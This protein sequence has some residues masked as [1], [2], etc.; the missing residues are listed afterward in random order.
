MLQQFDSTEIKLRVVRTQPV[1]NH[2]RKGIVISD[3]MGI[4][5]E[6]VFVPGPLTL[7]LP[8]MDGTRDL[9]TLK[10]GFELHTGNAISAMTVEQVVKKYQRHSPTREQS[11]HK[12][13]LTS[14]TRPI[15]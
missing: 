14:R 4:S 13:Y 3:P 12:M 10:T 1:I 6:M 11:M 15:E 7:L 8:L 2:G 9:E 5:D